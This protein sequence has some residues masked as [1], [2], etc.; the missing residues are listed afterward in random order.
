MKNK[1]VLTLLADQQEVFKV[2]PCRLSPRGCEFICNEE[3]IDLFRTKSN[4]KN[5]GDYMGF[6]VCLGLFPHS[7]PWPQNLT[8]RGQVTSVRRSAQNCYCIFLQFDKVSLDG[9]RLMAEH[10]SDSVSQID[11]VQSKSA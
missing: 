4:E 10:L 9:Y 8:A 7:G 2:G 6:Q 11:S 5:P 3:Q 1:A